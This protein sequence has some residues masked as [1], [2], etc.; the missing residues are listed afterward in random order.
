MQ[1]ITVIPYRAAHLLAIALRENG[2]HLLG[3]LTSKHAEDLEKTN[4]FTIMAGEKPIACYGMLEHWEGRFELWEYVA[5]DAT[6]DESAEVENAIKNFIGDHPGR[7]IEFYADN[8]FLVNHQRA[9][10]FGFERETER[11]EKYW[12]NGR[13][14]TSYVRVKKWS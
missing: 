10:G 5:S 14:A 9:K 7:R 1:N 2:H 11:I 3:Y 8:E 6:T 4:A 13:T 12:A